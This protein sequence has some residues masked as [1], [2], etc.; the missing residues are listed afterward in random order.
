[1]LIFIINIIIIIIIIII[2]HG[3]SPRP[4]RGTDGDPTHPRRANPTKE[5][6]LYKEVPQKGK[7]SRKGNPLEREIL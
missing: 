6:P 1:M 3:S 2:I 5:N 4:P 7:S